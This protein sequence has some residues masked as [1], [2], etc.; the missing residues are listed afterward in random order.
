MGCGRAETHM[1]G[2]PLQA[3]WKRAADGIGMAGIAVFLLLNT[4]GVLPW[5]FWI[6]A[7]AL[8]PLLIM[9]AG[10][11]IAFEKTRAPWLVLFG[12]A[13]V[14]GGLAW[15]ATGTRTD[16]PAG[17]WK[18]EGPLP[19][20]E[21]AKRVRLDL[22]L[23]GSRLQVVSRELEAGALA[24]AR[25]IERLASASLEV[26]REDETAH[27]RLDSGTK[28]GIVVLPGRRQRWELGVPSDL[29]LDYELRGAMV[30]SSFDLT[31]SRLQGGGINGV[32]LI[33]RLTLPAVES[34]VKLR[35]NGV[36]NVL[37]VSVPH[38]TPVRVRGTGFPFNLVKR[39]V[40]G[41]PERPGYEIQV[42]GIFNAVAVDPRP[43]TRRD[44]PPAE[45]PPARPPASERPKPEAEPAPP[46]PPAPV[47]G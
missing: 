37:R 1:S 12:P 14:L 4:T 44:A 6:D 2:E 10:V 47:R 21:G 32:F 39:R 28:N 24:D 16:I 40:V 11:K 9:S 36:F 46:P 27:V 5:S 26:K 42:D 13:I 38:G 25:S 33:T 17:P 19:R 22:D 18:A 3:D 15:M 41:D 29:P 35:V 8:W 23:F 34:P 7:I 45:A 31:H 20:P 43:E 30:R